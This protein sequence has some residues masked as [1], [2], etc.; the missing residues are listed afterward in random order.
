MSEYPAM[1][2]NRTRSLADLDNTG[3]L[4][5]GFEELLATI[6]EERV[7]LSVTSPEGA[8]RVLLDTRPARPE[9]IA[10]RKR[11][12]VMRELGRAGTG[13]VHVDANH[14]LAA[15]P[16]TVG[17]RSEAG[18]E[19]SL[20]DERETAYDELGGLRRHG[21][22]SPEVAARLESKDA[23]EKV[24]RDYEPWMRDVSLAVERYA[25][26]DL[27]VADI[28]EMGKKDQRILALYVDGFMEG[29][30]A[31][32]RLIVQ[33]EGV[34]DRHEFFKKYTTT[35]YGVPTPEMFME[36]K[37]VLDTLTQVIDEKGAA[38]HLCALA[39]QISPSRE[40]RRHTR[41]SNKVSKK[42]TPHVR[43]DNE[44]TSYVVELV[45]RSGALFEP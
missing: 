35:E 22:E 29:L 33:F 8:E 16:N 18:D 27:E 1:Y 25:L 37:Q 5:E 42:N 11:A 34:A 7:Q 44:S 39:K 20:E 19:Y 15:T 40:A 3:T 4:F 6:P 21:H 10:D 36:Y 23:I 24:I 43:Y 12:I 30:S 14:V 32:K 9:S 13:D 38:T 28:Q 31:I 26:F 2:S 41:K 17:V 45:P